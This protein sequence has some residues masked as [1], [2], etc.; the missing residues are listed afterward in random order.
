[1]KIKIKN[2]Y[3]SNEIIHEAACFI[4]VH[5]FLVLNVCMCETNKVDRRG[6][7]LCF[8]QTHKC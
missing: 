5:C 8:I 2:F 4:F 6:E 1:M 7:G 3:D